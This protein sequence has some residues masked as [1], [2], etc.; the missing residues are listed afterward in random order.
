MVISKPPDVA[1]AERAR[2]GEPQARDSV[3]FQAQ[4]ARALPLPSNYRR[5]N[6]ILLGALCF[7]PNS[8]ASGLSFRPLDS[9]VPSAISSERGP[10]A[11]SIELHP[12]PT[13]SNLTSL[14]PLLH[15]AAHLPCP[16]KSPNRV[17][18]PLSPVFLPILPQAITFCPQKTPF[19]PRQNC[20]IL[21][22]PLK[23]IPNLH[24]IH[25]VHH[26][27]LPSRRA[28]SPVR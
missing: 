4:T 6:A 1:R 5:P 23:R 28:R 14:P 25:N 21:F 27:L 3:V 19:A 11:S 8:P 18:C 26:S 20:L 2:L 10:C 12:T 16:D 9:S 22:A 13:T 7:I 15:Q 17:S 24:H